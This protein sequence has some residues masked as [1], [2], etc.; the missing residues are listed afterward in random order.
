ELHR[1]PS[2]ARVQRSRRRG[3]H[4]V[5]SPK[6]RAGIYPE[7]D[8]RAIPVFGDAFRSYSC[9]CSCSCSCSSFCEPKSEQEQEQEQEQ[10]RQLGDYASKQRRCF[11]STAATSRSACTASS[12]RTT[13]FSRLP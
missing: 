7:G 6:G 2:P 10:E 13:H 1:S 12:G 4:P 3:P 8:R 5:P 9:S 11:S